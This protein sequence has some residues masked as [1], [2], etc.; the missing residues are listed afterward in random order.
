MATEDEPVRIA[1]LN[2]L[3]LAETA[4]EKGQWLRAFELLNSS[5]LIDNADAQN[6]LAW[7]HLSGK[8]TA[9]DPEKTVACLQKA[10]SHNYWPAKANLARV[11]QQGIGTEKNAKQVLNTKSQL[12]QVT[13]LWMSVGPIVGNGQFI[14]KHSNVRKARC[15]DPSTRVYWHT[16]D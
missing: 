10:V 16:C 15:L 6:L 3:S 11:Y 2:P 5:D 7:L 14:Y 13:R 4:L 12:C 1:N 8:G 9:K